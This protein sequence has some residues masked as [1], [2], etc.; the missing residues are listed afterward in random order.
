[1]SVVVRLQDM[2]DVPLTVRLETADR[3]RQVLEETVRVAKPGAEMNEVSV[4]AAVSASDLRLL[5]RG[6]LVLTIASTRRPRDL[7]LAG[8]VQPR[9]VCEIFQAP[10]SLAEA[11][12]E[13]EG[14]GNHSS[15][16]ASDSTLAEQHRPAGQA[17]LYVDSH[18][19][20]VYNVQLSQVSH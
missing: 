6:K 2:Q 11:A 17:W 10:L 4:T 16:P 8:A 5:T 9:A 3:A 20:L 18:G 15:A 1:M 12:A 19:A 14:S 7:A 13:Q